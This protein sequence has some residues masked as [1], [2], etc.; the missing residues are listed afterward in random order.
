MLLFMESITLSNLRNGFSLPPADS[1][2]PPKRMCSVWFADIYDI[3]SA[4]S[5]L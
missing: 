4:V 5:I 1:L 2:S 3:E